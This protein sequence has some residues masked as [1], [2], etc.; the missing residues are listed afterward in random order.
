MGQVPS[1]GQCAVLPSGLPPCCGG[2]PGGLQVLPL[3]RALDFSVVRTTAM[4]AGRGRG[5]AGRGRQD[6]LSQRREP[7]R[8]CPSWRGG[9]CDSMQPLDARLS[10][11]SAHLACPRITLHST[12]ARMQALGQSWQ[13]AGR[14]LT[15]IAAKL[16]ASQ[17]LDM[18][19]AITVQ[20]LVPSPHW[21]GV[22]LSRGVRLLVAVR[23]ARGSGRKGDMAEEGDEEEDNSSSSGKAR[24]YEV[25]G[26]EA[27]AKG[28][29]PV[30]RPSRLAPQSP[31]PQQQRLPPR[32]VPKGLPPLE[33][34]RATGTLRATAIKAAAAA[35]EAAPADGS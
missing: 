33:R 10:H 15:G 20:A 9:S 19:I 14:P 29:N 16:W 8:R 13:A 25:S 3:D 6:D 18:A 30:N 27:A 17:R 24:Q 21:L 32:P 28:P 12:S 2:S 1:G 35:T 26:R 4:N 23:V 31:P 5:A 34:R 11:R 22:A 7:R